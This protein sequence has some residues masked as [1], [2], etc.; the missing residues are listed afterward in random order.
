M[1]GE[2][3]MSAKNS[4][5]LSGKYF[6][7]SYGKRVKGIWIICRWKISVNVTIDFVLSNETGYRSYTWNYTGVMLASNYNL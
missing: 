1:N 2:G 3:S 5:S 6:S 4:G 7:L